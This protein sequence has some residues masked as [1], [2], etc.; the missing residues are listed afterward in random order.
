MGQNFVPDTV[1]QTLLF[2]P[3]LHD[4]VPEGHLA[5]FLVDVVS[6][7]DL[8][9]IYGS[10]G[11]KD[12]RGQAA[13]APEMM[14]RLLLYGYATGVYSSRRI[15][16]RTYE[17]V[18][19]R[20]LSGDQHP[21]HAT[22]AEF[23][24]RHLTALG[25]LFTQALQ[26]CAKAGLVKLGHVAIDGTKIKANASKHKAMSYKRMTE[27]EARLKQEIEAL[28]GQAEQTDAAEDAQY[29][30]NRRGD[31]LP[32]EL[33]RR[34]SRLQKIREAKAAL[35]AEAREKAEHERTETE[36]KLAERKKE[37]Q[38]TGKKK[39]GRK[40]DPP[41]PDQARPADKAQRNFTD[42]ES[43]IMPDGANKGSFI[44]AYNAQIAVDSASQVIVAAEVTQETVDTHQLLPMLAQ[45]EK[46]LERNPEKASADAG[47]FSEANV[48]GAVVEK[49]DLYI[50]TGRDKHGDPT[51]MPLGDAPP[52]ATVREQMRH[53]LSTEAGRAVYKMR[54]AIVEPVFG[55]IKERR[56]FRRF[57]LRGKQNVG[58]EWRLVCAVS[59]L[60]K[61]F[62]S[63][64]VPQTA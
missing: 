39:R 27:A 33:S 54:K 14:L 61:L 38:R 44:Q 11:E 56:G 8:S 59:N 63:G 18:A 51:E 19:F 23:R 31:E 13:Y 24:K 21:D 60:L 34:E 12:G 58:C 42:P 6:A 7:L 40:P 41:D 1:N 57:S 28:L 32:E 47:Y 48:T 17:D 46:N 35:E 29:G 22:L 37:E 53:K 26:L 49:I 2:P 20:Y 64:W 15:E 43:R 4:W 62:R 16:T 10:Y 45:I 25:S 36:K 30:K 52:G 55:Q 5:R 50:A 3:S 9:A